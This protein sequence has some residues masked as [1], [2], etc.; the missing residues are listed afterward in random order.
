V[1]TRWAKRLIER[2]NWIHHKGHLPRSD[3]KRCHG[4]VQAVHCVSLEK[5]GD[6][7]ATPF[8]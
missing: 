8:N 3:Q 2:F 6:G 1:P 5:S 4:D 7:V